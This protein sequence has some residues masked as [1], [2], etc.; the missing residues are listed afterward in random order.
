MLPVR[1]CTASSRSRFGPTR[2]SYMKPVGQ[3]HVLVTGKDGED[4]KASHNPT[5]AV[6]NINQ[7]D[8]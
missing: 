8:T 2:V 1:A 3:K 5:A 4:L 7:E 6:V